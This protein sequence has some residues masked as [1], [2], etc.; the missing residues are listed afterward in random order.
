MNMFITVCFKNKEKV[1]G[2]KRYDYELVKNEPVPALNSIIRMVDENDN[3]VCYKTRVKVVA[4]KE[5]ST[6]ANKKIKCV[7]SSLDE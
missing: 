7:L 4:I 1:F 5:N 3:P 2:G 6:T